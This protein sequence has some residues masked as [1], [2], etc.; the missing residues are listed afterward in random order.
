MHR[1]WKRYQAQPLETDSTLVIQMETIG[2]LHFVV[3]ISTC[4]AW[5]EGGIEPHL[6]AISFLSI[7]FDSCNKVLI[8]KNAIGAG[9]DVPKAA[10]RTARIMTSKHPR[11]RSG[12]YGWMI[13]RSCAP[14]N[15]PDNPCN[16]SAANPHFDTGLRRSNETMY[17][18][19]SYAKVEQDPL[20]P[21]QT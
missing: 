16:E 15:S 13:D 8:N 3:F 18:S 12:L 6:S 1:T 19:P 17:I 9:A 11:R 7:G 4:N 14:P 10:L 21:S 20:N 2:P 5:R